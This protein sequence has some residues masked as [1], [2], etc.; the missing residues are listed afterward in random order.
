[1]EYGVLHSWRLIDGAQR[2]LTYQKGKKSKKKR[3]RVGRKRVRRARRVVA[4]TGFWP[5]RFW[6]VWDAVHTHTLI[7]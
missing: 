4:G 6:G 5:W 7:P 1:M 2:H 3:Q